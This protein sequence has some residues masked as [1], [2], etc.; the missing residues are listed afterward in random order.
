MIDF[1]HQAEQPRPAYIARLSKI[2][3]ETIKNFGNN[4]EPSLPYWR[5][6]FPI[7]VVSFSVILS[8]V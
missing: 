7:Y 6:K 8:F 5:K 2:K 1:C 4:D 3:K